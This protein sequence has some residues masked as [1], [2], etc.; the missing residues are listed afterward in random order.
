MAWKGHHTPS[1]K[2]W[3]TGGPPIFDE[4][5]PLAAKAWSRTISDVVVSE[6]AGNGR[7]A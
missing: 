6:F 5:K 7:R 1:G 2:G 4:I 3:C